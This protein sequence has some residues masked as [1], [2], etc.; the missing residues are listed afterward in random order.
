MWQNLK[1]SASS[2]PHPWP[3]LGL[4]HL[5]QIVM[6]LIGWKW[7]RRRKSRRGQGWDW[8]RGK[9]HVTPLRHSDALWNEVAEIRPRME[10]DMGQKK[11]VRQRG[12]EESLRMRPRLGWDENRLWLAERGH[13]IWHA[14][15]PHPWLHLGFSKSEISEM[16]HKSL[17]FSFGKI[18]SQIY[19]CHDNEFTIYQ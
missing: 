15:W 13:M 18:A 8:G 2:W 7:V 3:F 19:T 17:T 14:S 6:S 10:T 9:N 1:I 11:C 4:F 12:Q 5:S 16:C